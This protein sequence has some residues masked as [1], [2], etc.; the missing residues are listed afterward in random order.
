MSIK[1]PEK[2][3]EETETELLKLKEAQ[4]RLKSKGENLVK[5]CIQMHA[6]SYKTLPKKV[7]RTKNYLRCRKIP[8]KIVKQA[9]H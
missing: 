6:K 1:Q 8:T 5:R 3:V 2:F 4:H 9:Q 7:K